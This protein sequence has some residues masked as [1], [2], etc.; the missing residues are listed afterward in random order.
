MIKQAWDRWFGV[1]VRIHPLF[2]VILLLSA[3]TGYFIEIVTLFGVVLIHEL[4]HAAAAKGFGWRLKEVQLLPFG[5]VAVTEES[6]SVP[7]W[8]EVV[9]VLAGPLQNVWLLML[10]WAAASLG[11]LPEAWGSYFVQANLLI[12]LFNLLPILPLDG[13]K[14]LQAALCLRLPYKT[15]MRCSLVISLAAGSLMTLAA[16]LNLLAG[17]GGI[18]LNWL[19]IGLFLLAVNGSDLRRLPYYFMRFLV[20]RETVWR[21]LAGRGALAWPIVV[22]GRR[23]VS[24]IVKLFMRDKLHLVYVVDE[25]GRICKVMPETRLIDHYFDETKRSLPL[26]E[27]FP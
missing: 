20:H 10:G 15:A 25:Q 12:A 5:G 11:L 21:R 2:S 22:G 7:L 16:C 6:G 4:G 23:S 13:G 1:R 18:Q 19:L 3:I 17:Q 24:D 9:V 14:L 8:Q 27:L 26:S